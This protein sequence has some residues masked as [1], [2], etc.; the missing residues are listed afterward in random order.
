MFFSKKED[1]QKEKTCKMRRL[2]A[3]SSGQSGL[4]DGQRKMIK[5]S[6]VTVVLLMFF[7]AFRAILRLYFFGGSLFG[8][9]V[10]VQVVEQINISTGEAV[11]KQLLLDFLQLREGMPY[12]DK[13]EG[14][15][16]GDLAKRQ[17]KILKTAPALSALTITRDSG[18]TISVTTTERVPLAIF[19]DK[20]FAIDRS[21]TVFVRYRGVAQLPVIKGFKSGSLSP[22]TKISSNRMLASALELIE[23]LNNGK[24]ELRKGTVVSIDV[25]KYDYIECELADQ[26]RLKL[27]WKNM[28]HGTDVGEE[29]LIAQLNGFVGTAR[30]PRSKGCRYF[31]ATVPG[32]CYSSMQN[33]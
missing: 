10:P 8:I 18:N 23:C 30:S 15:F 33:R 4:S 1:T 9:D 27:A 29:W 17:K 28:G 21:A 22:G 19:A 14:L 25:S 26:K 3:R 12:F 24:S 11:T 32:H 5:L 2:S 6:A 16:A 20:T 13:K 31:N 7:L